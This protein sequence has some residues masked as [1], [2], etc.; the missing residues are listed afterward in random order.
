MLRKLGPRSLL[1]LLWLALVFVLLQVAGFVYFDVFRVPA[2]GEYGYPNGLFIPHEQLDY[3]YTPGF[4]GSFIGGPYHGIPLRINDHGF[5][6]AVLSGADLRYTK[7]GEVD[8]AG[9]DLT[10]ARLL[11]ADLTGAS[12]VAAQLL[13]AEMKKTIAIGAKGLNRYQPPNQPV[14]PP[15]QPV[16]WAI[17]ISDRF[18]DPA[19]SRTVMITK[20][21]ETS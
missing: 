2:I 14:S 13:D 8:L 10:G 9:V 7:L 16:R 5:R 4:S 17:T 15:H 20:P 21:M 11:G 12:L 6:D 1:L 3:A 18:N 19:Q